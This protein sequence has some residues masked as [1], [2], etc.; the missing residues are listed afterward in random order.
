MSILVSTMCK[1]TACQ[2]AASCLLY[3]DFL[4][5]LH[6]PAGEDSPCPLFADPAECISRNHGLYCSIDNAPIALPGQKGGA[7]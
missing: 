2:R 7:Q 5:Y 4:S 1:G 3:N 6:R